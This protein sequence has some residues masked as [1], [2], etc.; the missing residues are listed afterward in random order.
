MLLRVVG[1]CL[2]VCGK[3]GA[4]GYGLWCSPSL[5]LPCACNCAMR[6][7]QTKAEDLDSEMGEM[8]RARVVYALR[9]AKEAAAA[10]SAAPATKEATP[11]RVAAVEPV[12]A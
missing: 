3:V 9:T 5:P 7:G 10:G 1:W 6:P 11:V 4:V 8:L 2:H 12:L